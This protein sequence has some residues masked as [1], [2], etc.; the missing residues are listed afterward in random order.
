MKKNSFFIVLIIA[1][2]VFLMNGCKKTENPKSSSIEKTDNEFLNPIDLDDSKNTIE[3]FRNAT[4]GMTKDEVKESE[5]IKVIFDEIEDGIAYEGKFNGRN[6]YIMYYFNDN[7]VLYQGGY[8]INEYLTSLELYIKEADEDYIFNLGIKE[9]ETIYSE[10]V[11]EYGESDFGI[12]ELWY[13]EEYKDNPDK[14]GLAI[15]LGHLRKSAV[16]NS[17]NTS[18]DISIYGENNDICIFIQFSSYG[19]HPQYVEETYSAE[20]V[21]SV[22]YTYKDDSRNLGIFCSAAIINT[23]NVPIKIS[24]VSFDIED[25]DGTFVTSI[26][27]YTKPNPEVIQPGEISYISEMVMEDNI[28]EEDCYKLIPNY[29]YEQTTEEVIKYDVE[30]VNII[31]SHGPYWGV[32]GRVVNNM[33]STTENTIYIS[34]VLYDKDDNLL[35]VIVPFFNDPINANSKRGFSRTDTPMPQSAFELEDIDK[36]ISLATSRKKWL[37]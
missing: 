11:D 23:G 2:V 9:F 13:D 21:D 32:S 7:S 26:N 20:T 15:S 5:L 3:G 35:G 12:S 31:P 19:M 14:Y 25:E 10:L 34:I 16:W 30:D 29:L 17:E 6:S 27:R 28:Q 22:L 33:S 18:L 37:D 36:I 4:W 24:N 8:L 1:I